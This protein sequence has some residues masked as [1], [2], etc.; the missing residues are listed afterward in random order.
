MDKTPQ[1]EGGILATLRRMLRTLRDVAGNRAE[2][3]LVEW[4]EER[5]RLLDALLVLLVG[6]ICALMALLA[7]TFVVVVIFWDTH[8]ILVLA[9]I[10]LAYT[11]GAATAFG[12]LRSRM[13]RWRAFA[14]TLEQLR[15]DQACFKEKN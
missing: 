1:D 8:R 14:A 12:L 11:G 5:L 3:F 10:I 13:R 9:L 15:K 4:R 7:I 6:T 2:L